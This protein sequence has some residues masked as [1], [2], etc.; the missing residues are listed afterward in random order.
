[1]CYYDYAGNGKTHYIRKQLASCSEHVTIAV[2]EVFSPLSAIIKLR[3]LSLYKENVGLFFNFTIL[4]PGVSKALLRKLV[5]PLCLPP[6]QDSVG[7]AERSHYSKLMD[8]IGWFFFDLFLLG[9]VEDSDTGLS[10][11]IPGGL[12]WEIY[13][14]VSLITCMQM[15]VKLYERLGPFTE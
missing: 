3:S 1:M 13:I 11:R 2:N 12:K 4:P 7:D 10:F 6:P 15:N 5:H 14:E 8:V 9:Y